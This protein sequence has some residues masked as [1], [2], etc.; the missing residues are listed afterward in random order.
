MM[1][2][3]RKFTADGKFPKLPYTPFDSW[4]DQIDNL[5]PERLEEM[6]VM[7]LAV[8]AK[9]LLDKLNEVLSEIE[10]RAEEAK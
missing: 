6:S 3:P 5:P 7:R 9:N 4:A 8:T 10:K 1:P 2:H